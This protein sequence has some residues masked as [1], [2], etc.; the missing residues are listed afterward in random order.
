M[1]NEGWQVSSLPNQEWQTGG[2]LCGKI[3][4][5]PSSQGLGEAD[6]S[7]R[8]NTNSVFL[9]L[10]ITWTQKE[11]AKETQPKPD[12]SNFLSL[13]NNNDHNQLW[14]EAPAVT[15]DKREEVRLWDLR[16]QMAVTTCQG[17]LCDHWPQT[18]SLATQQW[19]PKSM[20]APGILPV[21]EVGLQCSNVHE[22]WT[23]SITKAERH[24]FLSNWLSNGWR[25]MG[26]FVGSKHPY[27]C[28]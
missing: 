25:A 15:I 6:I 24:Y 23:P 10:L 19:K 1:Q 12:N 22:A 14:A 28:L 17:L 9:V 7:E 21:W 8:M 26:C 18:I 27:R 16:F 2:R 11:Q 4:L 13:K 3:P 5:S 20:R